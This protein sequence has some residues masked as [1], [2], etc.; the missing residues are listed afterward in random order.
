MKRKL[1]SELIHWIEISRLYCRIIELKR[2]KTK[3]YGNL[4]R[5]GPHKAQIFECLV[6]R[7]CHYLKR[8]GGMA[9]LE[10]VCH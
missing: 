10:E 9:L 7:E 5:N 2:K 6:I 1:S 4:N 3:Q 8:L